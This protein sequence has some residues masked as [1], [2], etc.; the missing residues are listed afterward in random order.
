MQPMGHN[1]WGIEAG[2]GVR[3]LIFPHNSELWGPLHLVHNVQQGNTHSCKHFTY[4]TSLGRAC[5]PATQ[6]HR[7]G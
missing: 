5:R 4:N 7:Q 2:E 6:L 3:Q 1:L